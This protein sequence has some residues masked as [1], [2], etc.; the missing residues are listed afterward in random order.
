MVGCFIFQVLVLNL[1]VVALSNF[2]SLLDVDFYGH[3]DQFPET[4]KIGF[5]A[6]SVSVKFLGKLL[7]DAF[8]DLPAVFEET[9]FEALVGLTLDCVELFLGD[10][11]SVHVKKNI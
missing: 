4:L 3:F 5:F 11:I 7:D 10:V 9:L 2:L 1:G 6:I 8:V